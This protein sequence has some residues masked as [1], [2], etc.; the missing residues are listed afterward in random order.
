MERALRDRNESE[1]QWARTYCAM[2]LKLD[3]GAA[4]WRKRA[5]KVEEA[6]SSA[7]AKK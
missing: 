2:R 7:F 5:Q 1:L 3:P 6:L 4:E